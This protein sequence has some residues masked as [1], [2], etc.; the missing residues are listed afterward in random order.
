MELFCRELYIHFKHR[1]GKSALEF[2][3]PPKIIKNQL[4]AIRGYTI[5]NNCGIQTKCELKCL[6]S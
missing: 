3:Q 5:Y 6:K 2:Y 4:L 1:L